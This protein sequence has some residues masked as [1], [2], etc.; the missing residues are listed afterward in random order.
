VS[1]S[2]LSLAE[3][4]IDSAINGTAMCQAVGEDARACMG[5][6]NVTMAL[7]RLR[8][9]HERR[10]E[11]VDAIGRRQSIWF[12]SKPGFDKLALTSRSPRPSCAATSPARRAA[13]AC[14]RPATCSA[15]S[16]RRPSSGA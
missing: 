6:G 13:S 11:S 9:Y 15:S 16:P 14:A 5:L 7:R 3:H 1:H 10:F 8:P 4:H 12:V 2:T